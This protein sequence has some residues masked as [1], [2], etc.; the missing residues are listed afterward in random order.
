MSGVKP[1]GEPVSVRL[2]TPTLM[3]QCVGFMIGSA[4]FAIGAWLALW[5]HSD[6]TVSN[7]LYFAGSWFFTVA[8]LVQWFRAGPKTAPVS[9][10]PGSMV[11]AEWLAAVTQSF[12]T[13]LFNISTGAALVVYTVIGEQHLVWNPDAAGS[14]A[15]LVS[16]VFVLIA[17]AHENDER[18]VDPTEVGW[19]SGVINM[20][21]CI[22]FGVAA[23]AGIVLANGATKDP[24]HANLGT[25][26]GAVCFFVASAI[27]LPEA[28]RQ[29][30]VRY[31][32]DGRPYAH[33][34]HGHHK[35]AD[36]AAEVP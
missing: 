27:M 2:L 16:G 30:K 1:S 33:A 4:L 21:G 7:I 22:A 10:P 28:G 3:K 17:Y 31:H 29:A 20:L 5:T 11:R 25:F 32:R 12:G 14:V 13:V 24:F 35:K 23:V 19:W 9:Y 6:G 34:H 26:V 36:G 18:W 15:F 8:G